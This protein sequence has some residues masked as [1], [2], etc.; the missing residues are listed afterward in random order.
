MKWSAAPPVLPGTAVPHESRSRAGTAPPDTIAPP[1][2]S[3]A[4]HVPALARSS[5]GHRRSPSSASSLPAPATLSPIPDTLPPPIP[6]PPSTPPLLSHTTTPSRPR[7]TLPLP[8]PRPLQPKH[9][10]VR[11]PTASTA[12][13]RCILNRPV[14]TVSTHSSRRP[15][16]PR[17]L[18]LLAHPD[19][20]TR[21]PPARR[22]L[23]QRLHTST[24]ATNPVTTLLPSPPDW[25][26]PFVPAPP[27]MSPVFTVSGSTLRI[28][29]AS[30]WR[31]LDLPP[32]NAVTR[33]DRLHTP[34][35]TRP[36]ST[37]RSSA[38][39]PSLRLQ[40][41]ARYPERGPL[42][43][44]GNLLRLLTPRRDRPALLSGHWQ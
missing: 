8:T 16:Q 40:P 17:C 13:R 37:P 44:R 6:R 30:S 26:E 28:H 25:S 20:S 7:G 4:L 34:P 5:I 41:C 3:S 29:P 9:L 11:C 43:P 2:T 21:H 22:R 14:Q 27:C 10:A 18:D 23:D 35:D 42:T 1:R 24:A 19:T 33:L 39:T 15:R 31:C 32:R 38:R 12:R 36:R